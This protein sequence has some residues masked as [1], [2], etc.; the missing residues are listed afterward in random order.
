VDREEIEMRVEELREA[1]PDRQE[2]I[3]AIKGFGDTLTEKD[4]EVL[5]QVLL[6]RQPE[7]GGF[8]ALDRRIEEGGWF[9]RTGR[10]IE[11]SLENLERRQPK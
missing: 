11:E 4:R 6:D 2:F 3:T 9:K 1:N 5:G 7:R 10:K 8:D